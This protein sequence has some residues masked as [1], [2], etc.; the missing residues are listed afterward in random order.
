M[1]RKY[2]LTHELII[3]NNQVLYRIRALSDFFNVK[4]GDLG[5]FVE[6]INTISHV[7]TCWVSENARVFGNAW[8]YGDAQVF[9]NAQVFGASRVSETARIGDNAKVF[10]V[11]W[12]FDHAKISGDAIVCGNTNVFGDV[13]ITSGIWNRALWIENRPYLVSVTLQKILLR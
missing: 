2:E 9:G 5:G 11:A 1:L 10:G 3:I 13:N 8:I 4:A 12:V 6:A 7:G